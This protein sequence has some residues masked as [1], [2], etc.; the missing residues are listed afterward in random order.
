MPVLLTVL[1]NDIELND[2]D[3]V[4]ACYCAVMLSE[5]GHSKPSLRINLTDGVDVTVDRL[6]FDCSAAY[7][8]IVGENNGPFHRVGRQIPFTTT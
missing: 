1:L 3:F 7:W 2:D 8:S 5:C 4:P 6:Q